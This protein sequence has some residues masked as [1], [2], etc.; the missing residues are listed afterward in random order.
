MRPM[1]A[2]SDIPVIPAVTEK[3]INGAATIRSAFMKIVSTGRKRLSP[4]QRIVSAPSPAFIATPM[5]TP[6][7]RA[8]S[9]W[10][11]VLLSER[12]IRMEMTFSPFF[13]EWLILSR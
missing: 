2:V 1:S 10:T 8:I 12:W 3:K 11:A 7:T 9:V 13:H 4:T 5:T 6:R